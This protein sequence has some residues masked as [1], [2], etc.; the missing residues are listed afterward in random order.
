MS[1]GKVRNYFPGIN[2]LEVDS[3]PA[4]R[5]VIV[6]STF[7]GLCE[8]SNLHLIAGFVSGVIDSLDWGGTVRINMPGRCNFVYRL[9]VLLFYR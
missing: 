7:F 3:V 1:E 9:E 2:V 5:T 8:S 4:V 6:S